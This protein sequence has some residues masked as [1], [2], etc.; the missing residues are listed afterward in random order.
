MLKKKSFSKLGRSVIGWR[1]GLI[2]LGFMDLRWP[3]VARRSNV[4]LVIHV[5]VVH[6]V[7]VYSYIWVK[8]NHLW[9]EVCALINWFEI[10][11]APGCKYIH[12]E[13]GWLFTPVWW[14]SLEQDGISGAL[15]FQCNSINLGL[16]MKY[17]LGFC[18]FD[19]LRSILVHHF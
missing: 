12:P 4:G 6:Y 11:S 7:V 13:L 5:F 18:R 19:R 9:Q 16:E 2:M 17:N 1:S 10:E 8:P 15:W 14:I 3:R